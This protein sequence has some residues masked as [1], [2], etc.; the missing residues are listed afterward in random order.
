MNTKID[1]LLIRELGSINKYKDS[2]NL[3]GDYTL[4]INNVHSLELLNNLYIV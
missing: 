4:N 2:N 1:N 3:I